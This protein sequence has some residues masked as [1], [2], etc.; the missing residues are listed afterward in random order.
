MKEKGD[1]L[2]DSSKQVLDRNV[3]DNIGVLFNS[4]TPVSV[5][6]FCH[7][8]LKKERENQERCLQAAP[9]YKSM[10]GGIDGGRE[11]KSE[12]CQ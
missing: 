12:C 9:V 6:C 11:P 8:A 3:R 7:V 4:C 10:A 5:S 2:R 1:Y